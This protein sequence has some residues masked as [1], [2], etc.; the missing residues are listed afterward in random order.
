MEKR[1]KILVFLN[2]VNSCFATFNISSIEQQIVYMTKNFIDSELRIVK[3]LN[4]S[5]SFLKFA[6]INLKA[7]NVS[8]NVTKPLES[9]R[10]EIQNMATVK[11]FVNFENLSNFSLCEFSTSQS[12]LNEFEIWMQDKIIQNF[13]QNLTKLFEMRIKIT[14]EVYIKNIKTLRNFLSKEK[15]LWRTLMQFG[16]TGKEFTRHLQLLNINKIFLDNLKTFLRTQEKTLNCPIINNSFEEFGDDIE[17]NL[18]PYEIE[19][20]G[21]LIFLILINLF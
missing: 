14:E 12:S 16:E 6:V 13:Y 10:I 1:L 21:E 4:L 9:V 20:V 8:E 7:S 11:N 5:D 17:K 15:F 2:F 19:I 3:S 18:S